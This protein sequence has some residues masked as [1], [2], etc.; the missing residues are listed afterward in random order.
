MPTAG[1]GDAPLFAPC[2]GAPLN[3]VFVENFDGGF[4]AFTEDSPPGPGT[5]GTND[6]TVSTSGDTPSLNTGPE[7]TGECNGTTNVG[8]FIFLEGSSTAL[9]QTHCMTTS[10]V[11]PAGSSYVMTFW[12]HMFG[13]NIGDLEVLANGTSVFLLSGQQ[14]TANCQ[15][16]EQAIV[17]LSAFAGTTV[18]LQVC[19]SEGD[20]S[21]STFESDMA[22]DQ[23]EIFGC[24]ATA[25]PPPPTGGLGLP[26]AVCSDITVNL[27]GSG[28]DCSATLDSLMIAGASTSNCP[29]GSAPIITLSQ[30][31]VTGAD[32][33]DCT[34]AI[35]ILVAVNSTCDSRTAFCI[36]EI[37]IVNQANPALDCNT[38][39]VP[40]DGS[41]AGGLTNLSTLVTGS[42]CFGTPDIELSRS[43]NFDC[44]DAMN[45]PILIDVIGTDECG[46]FSTCTATVNVIDNIA[47][48][49][50]CPQDRTLS[51]SP[52]LC[53]Q[54]NTQ[55]TPVVTDNCGFTV[56]ASD[57][58]GF[59]SV[60]CNT[61]CD[62]PA[63]G[64]ATTYSFVAADGSGNETTC[65]YTVTLEDFT[66]ATQALTC[67]EAL[68]ITANTNCDFDITAQLMLE[69]EVG[70]FTCFDVDLE[71]IHTTTAL[72]QFRVTVTDP[73]TGVNCWGMVTVED[74]TDPTLV[75]VDCTDPNITDPDCVLNCTELPLFTTVDR[76]SGNIGY[77]EDLL[78]DLIPTD[79]DDF[80]DDFVTE[81]CGAPM[82]ADFSDLV[83]AS[84]TCDGGAILQR[85]WTVTFT[86]P[87]GS[88]GSLVCDRFYRFDP[89]PAITTTDA[90]GDITGVEAPVDDFGSP[91]TENDEDAGIIVEDVILMPRGEVNIPT[92]NVGTSPAAIAAFFD[93]DTDGRNGPGD[94]D[95][96]TDDDGIDPD[97]LDIDCVIENQEG[98]FMAYPHF[99]IQGIR[100]DGP[101]AQ[102]IIDGIC[103][104]NINF[105]DTQL[106]ACAPGCSGNSKLLRTWT[107]LDWCTNEFF[108]YNQVIN[109]IDDVA[110]TFV[111]EA[112]VASVDPAHCTADIA[113][114]APDKLTDACDSDLTYS[115]GFIEGALTVS[116]NA[117]DGFIL[118]DAPIGE[119]TVQYL[120]S[121]CC[122]NVARV[123]TTVTVADNTPPVPVTVQNVVIELTGVG[124]PTQGVSGSAKLFASDIDNGSFDGCTDVIVDIRRSPVCDPVDAEWGDFVSF[125]C[126]DLAGA[127]SVQ[128]EVEVRVRDW[129]D[130]VTIISSFV[131]LEDK[132]GGQGTCPPDVVI[133]CTDDLWDF[134]VTG[135]TPTS[136]S[137]CMETTQPVD[138]L[139]VFED[140]ERRTKNANDGGPTLGIFFG[141]RVE[142]FNPSCG[143]GAFRRDFDNCE[144]WIVVAPFSPTGELL[145]TIDDED[146]FVVPSGF[147]S[148][149]I[150]FPADI[151]VDCDVFDAGEPTF[152]EGACNLVG[153]TVETE[154]FDFEVDA[155]QKIVNTWTVI[156]WCAFDPTDPDLNPI[157]D[158]PGPGEDF[159]RFIH[160]SGEVEGRFV[161]TQVIKVIDTEAPILTSD[162]NLCFAATDECG[163]KGLT[164]SATGLDNGMCSSVWLSWEVDIDLFSDWAID[165]T[166]S[167]R[168]PEVLPSGEP[169]P[170][171]IAKTTNGEALTIAIP[172]GIRGSKTQHRVEWRLNDGC[173]NNASLTTFFTIEDKKA[174]TPVCLNLGTAVMDN[175]QVELWAIDFNNKSFD[176]CNGEDELLFTFTDV[177]PPPRCDAEYDSNSQ[178]MFY[179]GTFWFFDSSEIADGVQE[180][181]V[182]GA[183]EYM[184]LDDFGGEVHRWEPGLRSSGA[185]FTREN[186][187][188][189]GFLEVPIYVWD[190]CGNVDFCRTIVRIIDNDGGVSAGLVAGTVSTETSQRVE[191]VETSL[192]SNDPTY[193]RTDM[194]ELDGRFEFMD[195]DMSRD[196]EVSGSK[197]GDDGNGVS[198][199]DLVKIQRHILGI[200]ALDSPYKMIAADVNGDQRINGQDL[201][202]LR[203]LILGIYTELP[204]NDSWMILNA[205]QQLDINNPWDYD[206]TR[207]IND[208]S[209]DLINEDF[210]GVKIGDVDNDVEVGMQSGSEI[211][212]V[213]NL[214]SPMGV[215]NAGEEVTLTLS[216]EAALAGYQF[217][218]ETGMELVNV[219]GISEDRVAVHAGAIT[220]SENL[221]EV[222]T[223]ELLTI[224]L[225]A[226]QTGSVSELVAMT[227][228]IT[229]AEAYVGS[230]LEKVNLTL[231]G[232]SESDFS[233]G[234]NEPNPFTAETVISYTLP[235]AGP[236]TLTLMDVT[237]KILREV[238]ERGEAGA[239]KIELN[240]TGLGGGVIYYRL[241]AGDN[242]ATKH[243]IVIE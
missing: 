11:L 68:T 8:E 58:P 98:I 132:A 180:C 162:D 82:S 63:S 213:I 87:D 190:G 4:G 136:F 62:G 41:G 24:S 92:C 153:F 94:D 56:T 67:N 236:V 74:K 28:A 197:D 149:T 178:L 14:Q 152:L 154:V 233:L 30:T 174:P 52:G 234:Q 10:I 142:E 73:C 39:T 88:F 179:D 40:L 83:T 61:D 44:D 133:S 148:S 135:G 72:A 33:T 69:G 151:E 184:D 226:N 206:L 208:L 221:E 243:M 241:Q 210:I 156:D 3:S 228:G 182:T 96:D 219:S 211:G 91:I 7:T 161:Q 159:D 51:L 71:E 127:E 130:N 209:L 18:S 77:D 232:V 75:C 76:E 27:M 186:V 54:F 101:H 183:G 118:H 32:L 202:E 23:L 220:V 110:P 139:Q 124:T 242:V 31:E 106:E 85:T 167:S 81:A 172:D 93:L 22:F 86:R 15:P 137:T 125:C 79:R 80:L 192:M 35:G 111:V 43:L 201:V 1:F 164:I 204:E 215:V 146:R 49:I 181:G 171:F 185:I 16:W 163:S 235:E 214:S 108:D 65:S 107:V 225:R 123:V 194:T 112:V 114:P 230:G 116:G 205:G 100:P 231:N 117:E 188:D 196:Y 207:N 34:T 158:V 191:G 175:G 89:I 59:V 26:T 155:C 64:P 134:D 29:D 218:L 2:A 50:F 216:T 121:D 115:I 193:P 150:E 38:I 46:N 70:C 84:E 165:R 238:N 12:Y 147:D 66:P 9:G 102:P 19:M 45:S 143:F 217:T 60:T 120:S 131:T 145:V 129:N 6:L 203:K 222:Q 126:E 13:S 237:G 157:D 48:I 229:K 177:P 199:I 223:G 103:N 109:V 21:V 200:E 25:P 169:N 173:G 20:G 198:T 90:N 97:E 122:G 189:D 78:D 95:R 239:N 42:A 37:T 195:N 144:Q 55:P 166:L 187:S 224:T 53:G 5:T 227:S 119:T 17:D 47:P 240:K 168:V 57:D 140:T 105:T 170:D 160:D 176:N 141:V 128:I 113:L 99:Y 36:S 104:V 138:T 212:K